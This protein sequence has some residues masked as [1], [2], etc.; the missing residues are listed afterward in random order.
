MVLSFEPCTSATARA[1]GS[2]P[3]GSGPLSLKASGLAQSSTG[4]VRSIEGDTTKTAHHRDSEA[5]HLDPKDSLG[6]SSDPTTLGL[7]SRTSCSMSE[8]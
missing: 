3:K 7:L 5:H 4:A 6:V 1:K 8:V 2:D